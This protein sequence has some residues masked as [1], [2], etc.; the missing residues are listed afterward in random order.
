MA[1]EPDAQDAAKAPDPAAFVH[2]LVNALSDYATAE[3]ERLTLSASCVPATG[4]P[5]CCSWWWCS[6]P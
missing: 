6:L 1:T 2:G 5:A 4:S 3:R